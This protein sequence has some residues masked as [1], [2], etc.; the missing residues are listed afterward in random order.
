MGDDDLERE[1]DEAWYTWLHFGS[2]PAPA[3]GP[4]RSQEEAMAALDR[5][6]D[7]HGDRAGTYEAAGTVRMYAYRTRA[8]ARNADISDDIGKGGRV[9]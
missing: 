9:A 7:R 8:Q 2:S 3:R 6:R 4:F 5:F 1:E